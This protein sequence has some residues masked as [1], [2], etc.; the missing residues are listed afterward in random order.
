MIRTR[1]R[2]STRISAL[3]GV[4]EKDS[5]QIGR[6]RSFRGDLKA[7]VEKFARPAL[8]AIT[9]SRVLNLIKSTPHP[10]RSERALEVE[11]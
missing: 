8:T 5:A 4:S 10:H 7:I 3:E 1:V 2:G 9:R 6:N 11:R